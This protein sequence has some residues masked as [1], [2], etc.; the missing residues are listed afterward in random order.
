MYILNVNICGSSSLSSQGSKTLWFWA[1]G[2]EYNSSSSSSPVAGIMNHSLQES[3]ISRA[4][5][6][7]VSQLVLVNT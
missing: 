7:E 3:S 4:E 2:S 6:E 5:A 1:Q